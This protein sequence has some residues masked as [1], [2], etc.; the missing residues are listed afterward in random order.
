MDL[1]KIMDI[2]CE[3]LGY[4]GD[5]LSRNTLLEEIISD[6][7]EMKELMEN[8]S[9]ELDTEI[10]VEPGEDWTLGDLAQAISEL[11]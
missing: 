4:D 11:L 8:L 9:T 5:D 1:A 2:I 6:E 3:A 7:Y 10:S